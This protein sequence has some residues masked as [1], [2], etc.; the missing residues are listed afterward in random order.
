[1]QKPKLVVLK[2]GAVLFPRWPRLDA[3]L[4]RYE[5]EIILV[6]TILGALG[7]ACAFIFGGGDR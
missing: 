3:W 2:K 7:I 4:T 1:M 6:A 5:P